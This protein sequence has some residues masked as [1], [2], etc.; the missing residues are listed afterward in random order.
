MSRPS[1][2]ASP[3]ARLRQFCL[4]PKRPCRTTSGGFDESAA[5]CFSDASR[6]VLPA[7]VARQRCCRAMDDRATP[8]PGASAERS[9]STGERGVEEK[10]REKPGKSLRTRRD[11]GSCLSEEGAQR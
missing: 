9:I 1:R 5:A 2:W 4:L 11:A 8:V 6:T 10:A 7:T 3:F